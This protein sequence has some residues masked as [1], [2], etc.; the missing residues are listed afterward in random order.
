M[1]PHGQQWINPAAVANRTIGI[2]NATHKGTKLSVVWQYLSDLRLQG[3][4]QQL[5]PKEAAV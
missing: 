2:M 5:N 1:I 3:I 4:G